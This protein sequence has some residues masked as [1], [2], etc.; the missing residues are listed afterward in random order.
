M[1][2]VA[3][4]TVGTHR[5]FLRGRPRVWVSGVA[6][7]GESAAVAGSQRRQHHQQQLTATAGAAPGNRFA[8]SARVNGGPGRRPRVA[9]RFAVSGREET[10]ALGQRSS[11]RDPR[12]PD[13]NIEENAGAGFGS[14]SGGFPPVRIFP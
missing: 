5:S 13:P 9:T 10:R 3:L 12:G 4:S 6:V 8:A 7:D 2:P 11:S 1:S 14:P